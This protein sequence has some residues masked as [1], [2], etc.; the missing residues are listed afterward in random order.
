M[1]LL[2]TGYIGH[3][4][5][6]DDLLL[7]IAYEQM[8]K[9]DGVDLHVISTS[10]SGDAYLDIFLPAATIHRY[11]GNIPL[12]FYKQF[13]KVFF[14]GGGIFFDYREEI[15]L[16]VYL[17]NKLSNKLRFNFARMS[18]TRFAGLG[19]G[20]GP[21][22]SHRAKK[23]HGDIL[24]NFDI[25]GVRD[26]TSVKLVR[27]I[28]AVDPLLTND[29][30]LLL[31]QHA[32]LDSKNQMDKKS[33]IFCPRSYKHE[34]KYEKHLVNLRELSQRLN[35]DGHEVK[36]LFLQEEKADIYGFV[37]ESDKLIVWD[38]ESM[39]INDFIGFFEQSHA[40]ISSRM[41]SIYVAGIVGAPFIAINVH[42]KLTFASQLFY[43]KPLIIEPEA[44]VED[45]YACI[46]RLQELEKT[47]SDIKL[48]RT[49]LKDAYEKV[50]DWVFR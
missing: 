12:F 22:H 10:S 28:A 39:G 44:S 14:I 1:K 7:Y 4:N 25:L 36:W 6:G 9:L 18:G 24:D 41:H 35:G 34:E 30:S 17:K 2:L 45:Y 13:D 50:Y 48:E 16:K 43:K 46:S 27:E 31:E 42:Q 40:V 20:V 47:E 19:I 15:S 29:L 5:F 33:F 23:I 8:L 26:R 11:S 37:P 49:V 32:S 38:P 3:K 21:Y